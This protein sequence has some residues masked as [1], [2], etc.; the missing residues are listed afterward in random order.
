MTYLYWM[1][2]ITL[3]ET[4]FNTGWIC[5]RS[6]RSIVRI[7]VVLPCVLKLY[8]IFKSKCGIPQGSVQGH[9]LLLFYVNDLYACVD[10]LVQYADDT[11]INIS[12]SPAKIL[13]LEAFKQ[14]INVSR[15]II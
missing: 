7:T 15:E 12:A 8:V 3:L 2:M 5:S 9:V 14:F 6:T 13:K 11:T 10:G 4:V 1:K